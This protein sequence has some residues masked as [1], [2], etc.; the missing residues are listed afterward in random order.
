MNILKFPIILLLLFLSSINSEAQLHHGRE[1]DSLVL[2]CVDSHDVVIIGES[3]HNQAIF[4]DEFLRM[5]RNVMKFRRVTVLLEETQSFNRKFDTFLAKGDNAT[6]V[7]DPYRIHR[8]IGD[9]AFFH[10]LRELKKQAGEK[11]SII[12]LEDD[13][14]VEYTREQRTKY[15]QTQR[16]TITA[17]RLAAYIKKNPQEKVL[18]LYGSAH[19]GKDTT[20]PFPHL[21]HEL[22]RRGISVCSIIMDSRSNPRYKFQAA[23]SGDIM[24]TAKT[25]V[26]KSLYDPNK[27]RVD[28]SAFDFLLLLDRPY[29][30][31]LSIKN[32]PSANAI[33]NC[34]LIAR[35]F[36]QEFP[37]RGI[38]HIWYRYSGYSSSNLDSIEHALQSRNL[39][40][41]A[42][43][44]DMFKNLFGQKIPS[45]AI[46]PVFMD[47][48][49]ITIPG[50]RFEEDTDSTILA[51]WKTM[52]DKNWE[53]VTLRLMTGVLYYGTEEERRFA[54]E[55]LQSTFK[56]GWNDRSQWLH[57]YR[58]LSV[59]IG[60]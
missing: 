18:A 12:A 60:K 4:Q 38:G 56:K 30:H 11:L 21:G 14:P 50:R 26:D 24:I 6:L 28:P 40:Q 3:M 13:V 8:N 44:G 20:S 36:P 52:I 49:G 29:I 55:T 17:N 10:A 31:D 27:L 41:L 23:E 46:D 5:V 51:R 16:D 39:P 59:S 9:V 37:H 25:M 58:L 2:R 33:K 45:D 34:M 47:I 42:T 22:Q 1:I 35:R 15:Y 43:N 7:D 32:I 48:T 53:L 19:A 57:Q 54:L